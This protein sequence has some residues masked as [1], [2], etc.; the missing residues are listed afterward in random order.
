MQITKQAV[1]TERKQWPELMMC[2]CTPQLNLN[3]FTMERPYVNLSNQSSS[4]HS[5]DLG[6]LKDSNHTR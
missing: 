5:K 6:A 1:L 2:I 4:H 3:D